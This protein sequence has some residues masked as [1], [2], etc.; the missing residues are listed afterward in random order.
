MIQNILTDAKKRYLSDGVELLGIFGSY[1]RGKA[2]IYSDIDIA[3]RVDRERFDQAFRG[4]FAKL[5]RLKEIKEELEKRL[6]CKIDLVPLEH[7]APRA[8]EEI[9]KELVYV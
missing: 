8:K 1:T 9:L 2:D 4:G 3:Y 7:S 6:R 5:L